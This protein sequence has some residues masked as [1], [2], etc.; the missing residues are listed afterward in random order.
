M[1]NKRLVMKSCQQNP[2]EIEMWN[3]NWKENIR[4]VDSLVFSVSLRDSIRSWVSPLVIHK[5][6]LKHFTFETIPATIC[7]VWGEKKM[8]LSYLISY[9][10]HV[11]YNLWGRGIPIST[12]TWH[13]LNRLNS[14][15]TSDSVHGYLDLW[16]S[17][18]KSS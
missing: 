14:S 3:T 7:D 2:G 6:L 11:F 13:Y 9:T 10:D 8:I 18:L 15:G 12:P 4:I 1:E 5:Y 16:R 17:W